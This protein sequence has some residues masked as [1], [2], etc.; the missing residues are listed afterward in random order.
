[1]CIAIV[2]PIGVE[3]PTKEVLKNC[4]DNNPHSCGLAINNSTFKQN[5]VYK[6]VYDFELFYDL[7]HYFCKKD[8]LAFI[9]F[10]YATHGEINA[11]NCQPFFIDKIQNHQILKSDVLMHNGVFQLGELDANK[12]DTK[13][14]VEKIVNENIELS[15]EDII[16]SNNKIAIMKT[17]GEYVL[18]GRWVANENGCIFSNGSYKYSLK[19]AIKRTKN[20]NLNFCD[21]CGEIGE[22]YLETEVGYHFCKYC[23]DNKKVFLYNCNVCGI[24]TTDKVCSKC[25]EFNNIMLKYWK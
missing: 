21:C 1:M 16:K 17:N 22:N 20:L 5:L 23:I 24:K 3:L 9:H 2:K 14:L 7:C 18:Y 11:Y 6:G 15:N 19:H 25:S 10:R 12:S 4:F 8:I 13:T